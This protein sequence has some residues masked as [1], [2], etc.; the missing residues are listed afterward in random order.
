M[1]FADTPHYAMALKSEADTLSKV[2]DAYVFHEHLEPVNEAFY[3][4][5]FA[6]AAREHGLVYLAEANFRD[7]MVT[8]LPAPV[9]ET[10]TR[11][12]PDI[13]RLE[14]Y[15]DFVRNRMFRQTLLVHD[16]V[17]VNRRLDWQPLREMYFVGVAE[18]M[19]GVPRLDSDAEHSFRTAQGAI[20]AVGNPLI[21]AAMLLLWERR[22]QALAFADLLAEAQAMTAATTGSDGAADRTEQQ[23]A[24]LGAT[25]LHSYGAGWVEIRSWAPKFCITPSDSPAGEPDC[26]TAGKK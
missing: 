2:A 19:D 10:L 24:S 5:Q 6:E 23:A 18:P 20:F 21:K 12:A 1:R 17:V 25:L 3:F 16:D 15:M 11:I 7:M 13:V 22:P 8:N 4:H 9:I 26:A 14:Q